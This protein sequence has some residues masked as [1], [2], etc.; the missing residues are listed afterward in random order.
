MQIV[1]DICLHLCVGRDKSAGI[2]AIPPYD[3][4]NVEESPSFEE[5]RWSDGY[6]ISVDYCREYFKPVKLRGVIFE[7]NC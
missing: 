1:D 5:D 2:I 7:A 6:E 3:Q 4:W